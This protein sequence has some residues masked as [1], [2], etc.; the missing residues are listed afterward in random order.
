VDAER[1]PPDGERRRLAG[2]VPQ[3]P[4][5]GQRGRPDVQLPQEGAAQGEDAE[6]EAVAVR[7]RVG[8]HEVSPLQRRQQP[9]HRALAQPQLPGELRHS[10][11]AAGARQA[12]E[13]VHRLLDDA[14][15]ALASRRTGRAPGSQMRWPRFHV[16][17]E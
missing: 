4:Q 17:L 13:D 12:E 5:V 16:V 7:L 3:A 6:A 1:A 11:V 15:G 8:Q 14:R 2:L 10:H 9:V